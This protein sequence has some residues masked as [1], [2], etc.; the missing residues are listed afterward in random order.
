[1]HV[2]YLHGNY[3]TDRQVSSLPPEDRRIIEYSHMPL[4]PLQLYGRFLDR[5]LARAGEDDHQLFYV[6]R[7]GAADHR[8]IST[9]SPLCSNSNDT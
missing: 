3:I 4:R 5:R 8:M 9:Q 1:M 2:A 6:E 7:S